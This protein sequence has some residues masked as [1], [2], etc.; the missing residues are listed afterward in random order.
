MNFD[1]LVEGREFTKTFEDVRVEDMFVISSITRDNNPIH[2]D[3]EA[4]E[5]LGH[6]GRV[7]QG[8]INMSYATQAV[9]SALDSPAQ[10]ERINVRFERS[11]YEGET[12]RATCTVEEM[13]VDDSEG[14][15]DFSVALHKADGERALNGSA[16]AVFDEV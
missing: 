12:V 5:S 14:R 15:V 4:A 11:V 10:L 6:P 9:L 7:N 1:D 16:T 3:P 2:Y 8:S 13:S